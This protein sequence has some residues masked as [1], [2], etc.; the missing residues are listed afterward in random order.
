[1]TSP[2]SSTPVVAISEDLV[3]MEMGALMHIA[4]SEASFKDMPTNA[5]DHV[6][7]F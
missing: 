6:S 2:A 1:V 3:A 4:L 7:V 5:F